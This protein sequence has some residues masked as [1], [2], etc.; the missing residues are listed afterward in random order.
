[1]AFFKT[2]DFL[3]R[4]NAAILVDV[5]S[6]KGEMTLGKKADGLKVRVSAL[7][8][9]LSMCMDKDELLEYCERV[10]GVPPALLIDNAWHPV[11]RFF[12][13]NRFVPKPRDKSAPDIRDK[14]FQQRQE[15]SL[16]DAINDWSQP[17]QVDNFRYKIAHA[18]QAPE[19]GPHGRE[20]LVDV[21]VWDEVNFQYNV[22]CKMSHAADLGSGG[23]AGLQKTVPDLVEKIHNQVKDDLYGLGFNEGQTYHV[24]QIPTLMYGIPYIYA[25]R[26]FQGCPEVGGTIDYLYIGPDK[27]E[28]KDARFN[29]NFIPV[30]QYAKKKP[31]Y[32]RLRKRNVFN[33]MVKVNFTKMNSYNLPCIFTSGAGD[34]S[35]ARFVVDDRVPPTAVVRDL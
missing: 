29:G 8:L 24:N 6:E 4:N 1:M 13:D 26:M 3:K 25:L 15:K 10:K 28:I 16:V 33:D 14:E 32:L 27:V 2:I 22:S 7:M 11:T 17:I 18:K 12:K 20:N 23:I 31:F 35:A 30:E 19:F 5:V 9:G 34:F 21:V